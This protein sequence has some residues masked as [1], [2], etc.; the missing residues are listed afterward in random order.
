MGTRRVGLLAVLSICLCPHAASAAVGGEPD[1]AVRE[2]RAWPFEAVCYSQF[3]PIETFARPPTAELGTGP[4][5]AGLREVL[6]APPIPGLPP[7]GWRLASEEVGQAVFVHGSP[8]H[9]GEPIWLSIKQEGAGWKMRGTGNCEP[10]TTVHGL[11]A[12]QWSFLKVTPSLPPSTRTLRIR[13]FPRSC[14]SGM[15]QTTRARKPIFRQFGRR[16]TMT[17]LL[18]PLPPGVYT[19]Q[20]VLE[21]PLTVR[22]PGRLGNRR[23]FD[24]GMF[25]PQPVTG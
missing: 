25:P 18:E 14:S 15:P 16:L 21:P 12:A 10:Q 11:Y 5:E 19:C 6:A 23:L 3:D 13:L 17:I 2:W 7:G 24:G 4:S 20:G 22:L 8:S 1:P 9:P